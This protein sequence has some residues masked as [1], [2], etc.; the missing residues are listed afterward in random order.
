VR[1]AKCGNENSPTN[2]FCGMCGAVLGNPSQGNQAPRRVAAGAPV[3]GERKTL[4]EKTLGQGKLQPAEDLASAEPRLPP[5]PAPA[6]RSASTAPSIAGP[7]FLGLNDPGLNDGGE[8]PAGGHDS[9]KRSAGNLDYLLEDEEEPSRGWGKLA[10]VA[11][12][13][14]LAGGFGYLR[15]KQGGFDWVTSVKKP[16]VETLQGTPDSGSS[17]AGG[18]SDT[19]NASSSPVSRTPGSSEPIAGAAGPNANAAPDATNPNIA[20]TAT[21]RNAETPDAGNA[22][23]SAPAPAPLPNASAAETP[24]A[25]TAEADSS[26]PA[27]SDESEPEA[28]APKPEASV[29]KSARERKS[30]PATP[31]DLPAE[32]ERYI[33]GRGVAQ[34]CDRGLRLLKPE[35]QSDPKAMITLGSLYSSGTCTPRDL[36]SAYRW[37]ALALHKQPDN[38]RLQDDLQ[39]LWG[40]MTQPER[41]LAIKLSQ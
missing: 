18:P 41:Q 40:E 2:R 10:L 12:A 25:K 3:E 39:K 24:M 17:G 6:A 31:V 9:L 4:G 22:P 21:G 14:L 36:P 27:P 29:R 1:C 34:D 23:S 11:V 35:A 15:W 33:Y 13:L 37:F 20:G 7:S 16:A 5:R 19:S 38:V 30:A 32:A 26:Q 8:R 28:P